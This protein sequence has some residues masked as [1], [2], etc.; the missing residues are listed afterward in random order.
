[1][2][3]ILTLLVTLTATL[4]ITRIATVALMVTGLSREAARFQARSALTGVGFTT[5]ES[6]KV[7]NHPVRR[8]I[9]MI[10]MLTG[11]VGIVTVLA[12]FRAHGARAQWRN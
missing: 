4:V 7:T 1:M 5:L 9:I 3:A 8:H 10:L 12:T 11:N 2:V 6:E